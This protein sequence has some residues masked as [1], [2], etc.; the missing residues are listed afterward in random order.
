MGTT[1]GAGVRRQASS[2]AVVLKKSIN[3]VGRRNKRKEPETNEKEKISS[4]TYPR[5]DAKR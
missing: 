5:S 4:L 2:K 3:V 1:K